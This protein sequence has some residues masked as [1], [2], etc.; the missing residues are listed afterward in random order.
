VIKY[1]SFHYSAS[2]ALPLKESVIKVIGYYMSIKKRSSFFHFYQLRI[3][4]QH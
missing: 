3:L 4:F 1:F 2:S